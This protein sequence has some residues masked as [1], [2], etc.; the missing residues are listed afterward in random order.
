MG[1]LQLPNSLIF[2]F[3]IINE[4]IISYVIVLIKESIF[5]NNGME[6]NF[7]NDIEALICE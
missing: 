4:V 7:Y 3:F 1:L 5:Y 6:I 2:F